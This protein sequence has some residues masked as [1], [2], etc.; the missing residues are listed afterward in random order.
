MTVMEKMKKS[1]IDHVDPWA[2][3]QESKE[4]DFYREDATPH[5]DPM[6]VRFQVEV[7]KK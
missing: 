1:Q 6:N 5:D 3:M 4:P 2:L 7:K